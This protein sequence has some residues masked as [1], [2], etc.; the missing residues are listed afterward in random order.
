MPFSIY[1]GVHTLQ[2]CWI[3]STA[4]SLEANVIRSQNCIK[5]FEIPTYTVYITGLIYKPINIH[6]FYSFFTKDMRPMAQMYNDTLFDMFYNKKL[7]NS[8]CLFHFF[9]VFFTLCTRK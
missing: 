9:S 2:K 3:V 7:K 5:V 8:G 4:F 6:L 1:L